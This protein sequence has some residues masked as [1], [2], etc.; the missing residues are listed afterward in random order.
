VVVENRPGGDSMVSIN[1]FIGANDDH[2]LLW[3]PVGNF[4]VHPFDHEKLSYDA[5]RDLLPIVNVTTLP[6]AASTS[7][8]LN[9][10]SLRDFVGL[11]RSQPGKFNAAAASGAADFLMAGLIQSNGLQMA[12]VPYRDIMQGPP[13]LAEGRIQLL[14]SSFTIVQPLMTAG[15]IKV[16]AVTGS[17]RS[18]NA[19]GVATMAEAGFPALEFDSLGGLFGPRGMP[20]ATRERIADDVRAIVAGDPSIAARLLATSQVVNVLGPAEFAAGIKS[21]QDKF[22]SIAKATGRKPVR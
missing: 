9:I 2:V 21:M 1:A 12:K 16:L 4:A 20:L 3:M 11:V 8:T 14:M 7:A 10:G 5:D 19:P 13:D 17:K 18:P 15:R 6:L 22:A